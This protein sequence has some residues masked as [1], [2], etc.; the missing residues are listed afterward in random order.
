MASAKDIAVLERKLKEAKSNREKIVLA[1]ELKDLKSKLSTTQKTET[2]PTQR[3]KI[4]MLSSAEFSE[5]IARLKQKPEYSFLKRMGSK[6]IQDDYR[7][8][9]KPV[10]WRIKGKHNYKVPSKRFRAENPDAVYY[11]NRIN[12]SDVRRPNRLEK[13][14]KLSNSEFIDKS[15]VYDN[16]GESFDR[17][18]IFTPDGSVYGMSENAKGFNQY[19]GENN[20]IPKGNHLGKKLKS[21]PKEI[22]WAVLERM[23]TYAK[24]GKMATGGKIENQYRGMSDRTLWDSWKTIQKTHFLEDHRD[25]YNDSIE[26]DKYRN[27]DLVEMSYDELPKIVH[28]MIYEHRID[29][30][31]AKGGMMARGGYVSKGEMVWKKISDS[32]KMDFLYKNFTPEIT[33][34]SQEKLVGKSWN[35][36]P[37]NVKIKFESKYANVEDYAT[38][39]SLKKKDNENTY[40]WK[41]NQDIESRSGNNEPTFEVGKIKGYANALKTRD[42]LQEGV[43]DNFK[44]S[45]KPTNKYARGGNMKKITAYDIENGIGRKFPTEF[46]QSLEIIDVY[47]KNGQTMVKMMMNGSQDTGK[48]ENV[49]EFINMYG[50][51]MA[52]GGGVKKKDDTQPPTPKAVKNPMD[53]Y[54]VQLLE[55]QSDKKNEKGK[56]YMFPR[57]AN[58]NSE[59]VLFAKGGLTKREEDSEY[60]LYDLFKNKARANYSKFCELALKKGFSP[61]EI[62][63]WYEEHNEDKYANGGEIAVG[64][65]VAEKKGTARGKVYQDTGVFIK[66]EDK[67]GNKSNTLHSKSKFKKSVKP[68]Y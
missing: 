65:W 55:S 16:G 10:G 27:S 44:Y 30:Q 49:V 53:D 66:L 32:Q 18:T 19:L 13:G 42:A 59:G 38:G 63:E 54:N 67:Y 23:E 15:I 2:L 21:V 41:I 37:K 6:K 31:Y 28:S 61:V 12:R 39:G 60:V 4:R 50:K 24:G 17:Y 52:R 46:G 34:R 64:D 22:Q 26:L 14:G 36:L 47:K 7:V 43:P 68:R 45:I 33:P 11:E 57:P 29:G 9:G 35:F 62:D 1:K 40:I 8:V 5:L 3:R 56:Y 58:D 25:K 20:E 48:I 51:K